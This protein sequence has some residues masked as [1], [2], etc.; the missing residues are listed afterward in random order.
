V[1]H[2]TTGAGEATALTGQPLFVDSRIVVGGNDGK[3]YWFDGTLSGAKTGELTL[4]AEI[5]TQPL[6]RQKHLYVGTSGFDAIWCVDPVRRVVVWKQNFANMGGVSMPGA[7]LD[8]RVYF[9]TDKGRLYAL[10]PRRETCGWMYEVDGGKGFAC[11][12]LIAGRRVLAITKDGRIL[13]FDE[14]QE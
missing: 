6:A 1:E 5:L 4:A 11:R 3:L 8:N 7:G 2:W 10:D 9:G 12:P 13:G 14:Q